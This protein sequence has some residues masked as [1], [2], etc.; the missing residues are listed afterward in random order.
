M[1]KTL[2]RSDLDTIVDYELRKVRQRLADHHLELDLTEEAK[3]FLIDKGY[4]PDFGARPL[5]RAL[6]QYV[7]DPLAE[8]LLSGDFVAG[9]EILATRNPDQ[10]YLTFTGKRGDQPPAETPAPQPA[11][12][13]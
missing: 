1:F 8:N 5:R 11:T 10:E 4:N 9:D 12:T 13:S 2:N 6:G 3:E 7:E